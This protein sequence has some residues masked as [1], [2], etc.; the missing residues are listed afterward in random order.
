MSTQE[1]VDPW[2]GRHPS[3]AHFRTSFE[4]SHL[5]AGPL[6]DTSALFAGLALDL[7]AKLNDGIELS[8]GLRKLREAKDCCVVQ[9]L[10]DQRAV[11]LAALQGAE[12]GGRHADRG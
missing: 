4:F 10:M 8:A 7:L 6:R 2:V 12:D 1:L 5:P 3:V 9:A 11:A